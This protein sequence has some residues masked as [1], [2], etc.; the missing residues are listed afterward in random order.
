M[1]PKPPRSLTVDTL[2][3]EAARRR[4]IPTAELEP[5]L[6]DDVRAPVRVAYARRNRD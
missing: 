1:P 4:N 2:A 6:E 5:V 3:H